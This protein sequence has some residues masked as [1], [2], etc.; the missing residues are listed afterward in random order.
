MASVLFTLDK[1]KLANWSNIPCGEDNRKY[2]PREGTQF[3][4]QS[5]VKISYSVKLQ[6]KPEPKKCNAL[7][8]CPRKVLGKVNC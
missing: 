2:L 4:S 5:T 3:N 8:L 6:Q 1:L 7:E